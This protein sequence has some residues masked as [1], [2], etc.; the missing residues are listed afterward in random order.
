MP[1]CSGLQAVHELWSHSLPRTARA[2]PAPYQNSTLPIYSSYQ[3]V[4]SQLPLSSFF[5]SFL[6][7][8]SLCNFMASS[9]TY[10]LF[11]TSCTEKPIGLYAP[12]RLMSSFFS[13]LIRKKITSLLA[14][15]SA[16]HNL[17]IPPPSSESKLRTANLH[18]V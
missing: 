4:T 9:C 11:H 14:S 10:C 18:T 8:T 1:T 17:S 15:A 16:L 6:T 2:F 13:F 5:P 7:S 12:L 3:I